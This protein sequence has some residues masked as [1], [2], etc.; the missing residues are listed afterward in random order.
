[1]IRSHDSKIH[2]ILRD[3]YTEGKCT[4]KEI[5]SNQTMG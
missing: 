3:C 1:M 5:R 2:D 4:F